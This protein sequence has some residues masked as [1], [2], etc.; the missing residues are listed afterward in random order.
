MSQQISRITRRLETHPVDPARTPGDGSTG[1][2]DSTALPVVD[3][4]GLSMAGFAYMESPG[5][6]AAAKV[7][8]AITAYLYSV[9]NVREMHG[10]E[11]YPSLQ[12]VREALA[13]AR[14][15]RDHA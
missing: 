15:E 2:Q 12:E 4:A 6:T 7:R 11:C 5:P 1:S 8:D 3:R 9:E 13:R 10:L 14:E